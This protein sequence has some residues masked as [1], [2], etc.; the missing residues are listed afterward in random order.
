M[1]RP[2]D[3]R[4]KLSQN[5]TVA[6]VRVVWKNLEDFSLLQPVY[7]TMQSSLESFKDASENLITFE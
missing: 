7:F 1:G 5:I 3:M 2:H 6:A 4:L